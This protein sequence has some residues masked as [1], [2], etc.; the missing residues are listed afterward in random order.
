MVDQSNI[1]TQSS[2]RRDAGSASGITKPVGGRPLFRHGQDFLN[3]I[4]L[5]NSILSVRLPL[6][7]EMLIYCL[8]ATN[9]NAK[10][11]TRF[12]FRLQIGRL[13]SRFGESPMTRA[14][15][16]NESALP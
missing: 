7:K 5:P 14:E 1:E 16:L 6:I 12:F 9:Q 8:L 4:K 15:A 10:E 11:K 13:H 2:C 3:R